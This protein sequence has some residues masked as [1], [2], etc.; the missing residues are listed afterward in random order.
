MMQA[1]SQTQACLEISASMLS[2]IQGALSVC[3][4]ILHTL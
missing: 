1:C 3:M 2:L 4:E